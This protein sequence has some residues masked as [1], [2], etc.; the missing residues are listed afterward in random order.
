MN[1]YAIVF[2]EWMP[3]LDLKVNEYMRKGWRSQ[4]GVCFYDR[5][6]SPLLFQAMIKGKEAS[7]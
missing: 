3:E 1:R 2:G 7:P 4:G 6:G 5:K